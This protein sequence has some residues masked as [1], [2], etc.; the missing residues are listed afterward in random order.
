MTPIRSLLLIVAAGLALCLPA[1]ADENA[2]RERTS[3][4]ADWRFMKGEPAGG[5]DQ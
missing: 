2:T 3:F 4:N 1:H 5:D